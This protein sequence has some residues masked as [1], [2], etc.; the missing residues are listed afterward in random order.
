[1]A[2]VRRGL[3]VVGIVLAAGAVALDNR[4]VGWAAIALLLVSLLLRLA[5]RLRRPGHPA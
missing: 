3:A 5:E 4:R 1:M 2:A